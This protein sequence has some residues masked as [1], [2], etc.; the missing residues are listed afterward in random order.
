V[1]GSFQGRRQHRA[2]LAAATEE[3]DL[4]A[5]RA[6]PGFHVLD[7][8]EEALL[9]RPDP[10]GRELLRREEHLRQ[11]GQRVRLDRVD[12]GH[13]PPDREQLR[14]GDQRLPETAHAV[15]GRLH[16]EQDPPLQVLLRPLELLGPHVAAG[17]VGDLL[18]HDLQQAAR[19]SSRVP[20]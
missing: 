18:A 11:L 19:L 8:L 6:S 9:P 16:R 20:M 15:R 7:R 5:A 14:V 17:D 1:P 10:G 3:R 2:D 4:H 12:L 13:D